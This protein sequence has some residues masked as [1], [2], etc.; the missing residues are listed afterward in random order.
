MTLAAVWSFFRQHWWRFL[1]AIP[2]LSLIAVLGYFY[3][4]SREIDDYSSPS[5]TADPARP[6]MV[7]LGDSFTAGEGG[8]R[9]LNGT[10]TGSN[11]CHR[12]NSAY[13]YLV[14]VALNY[15]LVT[16]ACSGAVVKDLSEG[17]HKGSPPDVYGGV[18][19][20]NALRQPRVT[21]EAKVEQGDPKIVLL[22]IGGNDALFSK[23][24]T[25]CL[26]TNSCYGQKRPWLRNLSRVVDER[27][28]NAFDQ[29]RAAAPPKSRV[30]VVTY[31]SPFVAGHCFDPL[32]IP[33]I[34]YVTEDFLPELN[35]LINYQAAARGFEVV[36][37]T[38][39][40]DGARICEDGEPSKDRAM[41]LFALSKSHGGPISDT[42]RGS[43]HP[44][45]LGQSLMAKAVLAKLTEKPSAP[46][47]CGAPADCP[48]HTPPQ[49][50]PPTVDKFPEGTQCNGTSLG[51]SYITVLN[52]G[53]TRFAVSG[54]PRSKVCYRLYKQDWRAKTLSKTGAYSL[55]IRSVATAERPAVDVLVESASSRQWELNTL[56][57]P[58]S[59]LPGQTPFLEAYV[60]RIAAVVAFLILLAVAPWV[61]LGFRS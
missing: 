32:S 11:D 30:L 1:F 49:A 29:V 39:T 4:T 26:N 14:A 18:P 38:H 7:A 60:G 55:D 35:R 28:A 9:Y 3:L 44:T 19:Q 21:P 23:L 48:R 8:L 56:V 59:A 40:F 51:R 17:Q 54:A 15:R 52:E 25:T 43:F 6:L 37:N 47:P 33:E 10:N 53:Q 24:V 45:P 2:I 16:A 34:R 31:P 61:W 42:F 41:N 27:L 22:S 12:A 58:E 46:P 20:I 5:P 36:D 57:P 50:K 13:P